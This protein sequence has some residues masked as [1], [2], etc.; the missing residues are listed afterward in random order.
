MWADAMSEGRRL[1]FGDLVAGV[2]LV[3]AAVLAPL[4]LGACTGGTE[5]AA[6]YAPRPGGDPERGRAAIA[7]YGCGSCHS[8]PGVSGAN[9]RVAP[10]LDSFARRTYVGGEVPNT[11]ENLVRW[12]ENPQSIEPRTAMP[13]L[14]IGDQQARDIAAYLYTLE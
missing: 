6:A 12:I 3:L 4:A 10:P 7:Q 13:A 1:R 11:P 14:G 8:I 2:A 9:G 5:V